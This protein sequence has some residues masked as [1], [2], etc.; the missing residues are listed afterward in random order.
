MVTDEIFPAFIRL[1]EVIMEDEDGVN[2]LSSILAMFV[3]EIWLKNKGLVIE[4]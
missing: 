1:L 4:S 2:Q 3:H